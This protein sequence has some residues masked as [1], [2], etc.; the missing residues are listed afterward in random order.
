MQV[1]STAQVRITKKDAERLAMR[2]VDHAFD[3]GQITILGYSYGEFVN[4]IAEELED[5][6]FEQE[7]TVEVEPE[8]R[9]EP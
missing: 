2:L 6:E 3:I 4:K 9:D 7:V 5:Y 8:E 1:N